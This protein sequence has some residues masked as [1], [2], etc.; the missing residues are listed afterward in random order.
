M[1]GRSIVGQALLVIYL[2]VDMNFFL[3]SRLPFTMCN[4]IES[5]GA[6]FVGLDLITASFA[7][8]GQTMLRCWTKASSNNM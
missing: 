6:G 1:L 3:V 5:V 2:Y 7:T 4:N 8:R